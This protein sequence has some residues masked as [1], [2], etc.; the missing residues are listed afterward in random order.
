MSYLPIL[1]KGEKGSIYDL[2]T[3]NNKRK[4]EFSID[5]GKL[6]NFESS[7]YPQR[8]MGFSFEINE[9]QNLYIKLQDLQADWDLY[10]AQQDKNSH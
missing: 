3:I 4:K 10:L 5:P 9:K 6:E 1:Y 7:E 8:S 2:G